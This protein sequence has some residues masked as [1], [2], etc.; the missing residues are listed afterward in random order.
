MKTILR[1]YAIHLLAILGL[2]YIFNGS[3]IILG[4]FINYLL[5]ALILTCLNLLLKPILKILF[6]PV[7]LLTLGIFSLVINVL[8]FYIFIKL[9][10]FVMIKSWMFTGLTIGAVTI[11]A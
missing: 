8:V 4:N 11:S 5:A 9:T 6:F 2:T 10:S 7:N 3:F 1:V